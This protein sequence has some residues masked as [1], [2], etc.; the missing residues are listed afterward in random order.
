MYG[1]SR[2]G[3][4]TTTVGPHGGSA[5]MDTL[6]CDISSCLLRPAARKDHWQSSKSDRGLDDDVVLESSRQGER[7]AVFFSGVVEGSELGS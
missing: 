6:N 3:D 1:R 2:T 5:E 4:G 7:Y